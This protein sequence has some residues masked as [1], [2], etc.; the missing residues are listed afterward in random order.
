MLRVGPDGHRGRDY[1]AKGGLV[2]VDVDDAAGALLL[3]HPR[4]RRV[5]VHD[6]G[7]AVV[8]A[9][10]YGHDAVGVLDRKVG[11]GG[12]VHAEHVHG[13]GL[14][15]VKDAHAVDRRGHRDLGLG[16]H[17][18]QDLWAVAR[19]LADVEDGPLGAVDDLAGLLDGL[20]V[21]HRRGID[22]RLR[23]LPEDRRRDLRLRGHDV[24]RQVYVDGARPA[25]QGNPEGL[26]N[27]PRQLIEVQA[28]VVPLRAWACD[29]R[30]GALLEGVR[31]HG[32]G[33]HLPGEDDH[34]NSVC[35]G[36]LQGSH[37]VGDPRAARHDGHATSACRLRVG[38]GRVAAALLVRRRD[39]L[40]ALPMEGVDERQHGTATVAEDGINAMLLD[41]VEDHL[42]TRHLL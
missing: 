4:L 27:S 23:R 21:H 11:V 13:E 2:N 42:A 3:R 38:G 37:E 10:A 6:A 25:R 34:G 28:D 18:S 22:R 19:S 24:L 5:L 17:L 31:T 35:Q 26:V 32:A 14:A 15:L 29:L 30:C 36:V 39:P 16:R 9:A 12:A 8:E 20:H 1:L 41:H 40:D 33:R 7:R